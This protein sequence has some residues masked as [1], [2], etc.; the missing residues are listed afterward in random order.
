MKYST[1]IID[2]PYLYHRSSKAPYKLLTSDGRDVTGIHASLKTINSFRKKFNLNKIKITWESYGTPSWR[3]KLSSDYKSN[4]R[5]S[6]DPTQLKDLQ[7]LLHLFDLEQ[8]Y[9]P[10]NE[11]DDVIASLKKSSSKDI[12]IFTTDKDIMQ[13]VDENTHIYTG[14]KIIRINDVKERF[15]IDPDKIPDLLAIAGDVSDNII[16]LYKVGFKK[17]AKIVNRYGSV[18]SYVD[19]DKFHLNVKNRLIM[20]KSLA[21]LNDNCEVKKLYNKKANKNEVDKLINKMLDKYE[22]K[23]IKENLNEYKLLKNF[24]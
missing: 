2:G 23:S 9:S 14:K 18:E 6:I 22:L 11:A 3:K 13:L 19:G 1:L 12:I 7:Y 5:G 8:Y 15:L 17:A 24:A 16:G 20:N 10:E 21:L 4:T